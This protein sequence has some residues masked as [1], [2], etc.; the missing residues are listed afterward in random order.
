L[1]FRGERE[2]SDALAAQDADNLDRVP[3]GTRRGRR[4]DAQET[5]TRV[6]DAARRPSTP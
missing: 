4:A 2:V 6:R 5:R 1:E 3:R